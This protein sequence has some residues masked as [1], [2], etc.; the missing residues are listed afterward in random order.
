MTDLLIRMEIPFLA[1]PE[2]N[3]DSYMIFHM[4]LPLKNEDFLYIEKDDLKLKLWFDV[5]TT[6]WGSQPTE[7]EIKKIINIPARKI[8]ADITVSNLN[9]TLLNYISTHDYSKKPGPQEEEFQKEY[10]LLSQR[11]KEFTLNNLNRLISYVRVFKRQYWLQE[12]PLEREYDGFFS[13][14]ARIDDGKWFNWHLFNTH[15]LVVQ[16]E[17]NYDRYLNEA[18]WNFAKQFVCSS[19][20]TGLHWY[21][22]SG[23]EALAS[24]K[25]HRAALTEAVTALEVAI[26]LFATNVSDQSSFNHH[27]SNRM[28]NRKL[29]SQIAH[30]GLSGTINYLFPVL[31]SEEQVPSEILTICQ[32]ALE[33]RGNV[34][35]NGQREIDSKK[36][37]TLIDGIYQF[38]KVLEKYKKS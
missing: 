30:M 20:K 13:S 33:I 14:K 35:H 15:H 11:I 19:Q 5:K 38:C 8:F 28:S 18:D 37:K 3:S 4:W 26:N 31:F 17:R 29:K 6:W 9:Q 36:L 24:I 7:E 10:D 34:V 23:A 2:A 16:L 25:N 22:L 27:F 12:Y 32:E 1:Y 21:L